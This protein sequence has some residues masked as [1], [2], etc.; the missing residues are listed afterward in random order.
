MVMAITKGLNGAIV[1]SL[2]TNMMANIVAVE[3]LI[4]R[5]EYCTSYLKAYRAELIS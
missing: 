2:D 4:G 3:A 5:D 1:N